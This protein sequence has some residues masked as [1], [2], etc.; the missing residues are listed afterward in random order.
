MICYGKIIKLG[1]KDQ[2]HRNGN[3]VGEIGEVL[4]EVARVGLRDVK[5]EQRLEEVGM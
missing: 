2:E 4:N 5:C 3:T 1:K